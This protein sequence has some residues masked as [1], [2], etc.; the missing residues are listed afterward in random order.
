MPRIFCAVEHRYGRGVFED[1][2]VG[3]RSNYIPVPL[4]ELLSVAA[5]NFSSD[6]SRDDRSTTY[7]CCFPVDFTFSAQNRDSRAKSGPG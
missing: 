3:S 6:L 7:R 4:E 2:V 1:E 5:L